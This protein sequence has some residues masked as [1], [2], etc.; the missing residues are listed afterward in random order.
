VPS[1]ATQGGVKGCGWH[2]MQGVRGSNP[3][4]STR[5]N[6][7]PPSA[8]SAVCQQ[9]ASQRP[10]RR[11]GGVDAE[12]GQVWGQARSSPASRSGG[13]SGA[14]RPGCRLMG[15]AGCNAQ[16]RD[17]QHPTLIAI[18]DGHVEVVL[19]PSGVELLAEGVRTSLLAN[20]A[21]RT[22][23]PEYEAT[24]LVCRLSDRA[25]WAGSPAASPP[26]GQSRAGPTRW[27]SSWTTPTP[28]RRSWGPP[29]YRCA[30]PSPA[31][32]SACQRATRTRAMRHGRL[33]AITATLA[34]AVVSLL[35]AGVVRPVWVVA[36]WT[37][38]IGRTAGKSV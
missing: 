33:L 19:D 18:L 36:A 17:H 20:R 30:R 4:S 3:L 8:L 27:P 7:S 24:G 32:A 15:T 2:G 38:E 23:G 21:P 31:T 12:L 10:P 14:R 25:T 26:T 29:G 5:H 16:W 34:L 35:T 6:A 28:P 9:S 11:P 22:G 1:E 37:T 13:R